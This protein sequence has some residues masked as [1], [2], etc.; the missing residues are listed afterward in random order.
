MPRSGFETAIP[1]AANQHVYEVQALD[2][3]GHV[4]GTSKAFSVTSG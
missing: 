2:S 4:I 3:K 1:V